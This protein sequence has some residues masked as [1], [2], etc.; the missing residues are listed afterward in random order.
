V[1]YGMDIGFIIFLWWFAL[2]GGNVVLKKRIALRLLFMG[3]KNL[4]EL[5]GLL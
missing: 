4:F 2:R 1:V 5:R 3:V